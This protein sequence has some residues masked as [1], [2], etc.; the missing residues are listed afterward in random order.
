MRKSLRSENSGYQYYNVSLQ[1]NLDKQGVMKKIIHFDFVYS[2]ACPAHTNSQNTPDN[3]NRV[4][5]P[6][7]QRSVLRISIDF[8]DIVWIEDLQE[9]CEK[10]LKQ[11]HK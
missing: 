1:G 7:S 4:A 3:R 2:S 11:R 6:H 8:N 10:R 9:M 5:V